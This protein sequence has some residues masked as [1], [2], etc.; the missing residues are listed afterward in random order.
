MKITSLAAEIF[1]APVDAQ[2]A[3]S[4]GISSSTTRTSMALTN[5]QS[6]PRDPFVS[7]APKVRILIIPSHDDLP[8]AEKD[9]L[10]RTEEDI[11]ASNQDLIETVRV[12]VAAKSKGKSS[13]NTP[14]QDDVCERGLESA[15]CGSA[16]RNS[17]Q[18]RRLNLINAVVDAQEREW[19]IGHF[20]A[21]ADVL[22]AISEQYSTQDKNKA[23]MLGASDEAYIRRLRRNTS[24][25]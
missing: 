4:S 9:K 16:E 12:I 20:H 5:P 22:K 13:R 14:Q 17:A 3:G 15:V 18:Q 25:P 1:D 8:Q 10:W 19:R 2:V 11:Q 24:M 23:R 6:A 7:F 21:D